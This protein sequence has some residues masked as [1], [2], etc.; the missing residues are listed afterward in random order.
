M[1]LLGIDLSDNNSNKFAG[2]KADFM[3][4]KATEGVTFVASTLQEKMQEIAKTHNEL[5]II[6]FY[7]YARPENN[8]NAGLEAEHFIKTIEP[9]IGQCLMAL[10]FEG[11]AA[12]WANRKTRGQWIDQFLG[13]ITYETG[14]IPFLYM[15]AYEFRIH[16]DLVH[17]PHYTW[18]AHYGVNKPAYVPENDYIWQY[19]GTPLD[20]SMYTGTK[21]Q[22]VKCAMKVI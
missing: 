1:A 17:E 9:H 13:K 6:G 20:T 22:L 19:C 18:V 21:E 7:H 14:V 15:S 11:N 4:L 12:S 2:M 10:D 3:F 8:P 16:K 5:P